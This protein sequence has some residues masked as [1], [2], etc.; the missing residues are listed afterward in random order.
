MQHY[1]KDVGLDI[2][3]EEWD[4]VN[5]EDPHLVKMDKYYLTYSG[6]DKAGNYRIGLAVSS[7]GEHYV[8]EPNPILDLGARGSFEEKFV[9]GNCLLYNKT[10]VV[11]YYHGRDAGNNERISLAYFTPIEGETTHNM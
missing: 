2:G 1:L 5:I 10:R 7:D 6:I 11:M 9:A 4:S 3:P 8:K